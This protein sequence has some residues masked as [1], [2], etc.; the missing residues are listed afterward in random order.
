MQHVLKNTYKHMFHAA[1]LNSVTPSS[2]FQNN[3]TA[4]EW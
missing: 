2:K 3:V 4:E 1:S